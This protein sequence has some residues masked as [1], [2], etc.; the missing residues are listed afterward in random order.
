MPSPALRDLALHSASQGINV[1]KCD[2]PQPDA[3]QVLLG[4][5]DATDA[6]PAFKHQ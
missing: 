5:A 6:L 1:S 2:V 3:R 4:E